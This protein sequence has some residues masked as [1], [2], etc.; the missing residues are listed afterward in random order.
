MKTDEQRA[1]HAAYMREWNA[2]NI[3]K[4][5][6]NGRATYYRDHERRKAHM[7][8]TYAAESERKKAEANERHAIRMQ[9]PEQR[10]KH[11]RVCR[12]HRARQRFPKHGI[13][14]HYAEEVRAIYDA[15]PEGMDVDHIEPVFA[16]IGGVVVACGLHVPWNLQYLD[17]AQNK[18]KLDGSAAVGAPRTKKSKTKTEEDRKAYMRAYYLQHKRSKET[19]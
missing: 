17:P 3:E 15:C 18:S 2:K 8:E 11:R 9:D 5:R 16:K 12:Y 10:E 19:T 14:A 4:A 7:R 13:T 1:K 6:A